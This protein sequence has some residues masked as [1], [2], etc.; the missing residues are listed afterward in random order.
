MPMDIDS[1]SRV[2]ALSKY[3]CNV[4]PAQLSLCKITADVLASAQ[5]LLQHLYMSKD[6][7]WSALTQVPLSLKGA[8]FLERCITLLVTRQRQYLQSKARRK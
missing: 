8:A 4:R 6:D 7:M 5:L 1:V 3:H 2:L